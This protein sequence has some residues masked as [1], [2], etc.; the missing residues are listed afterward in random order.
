M[1]H[2]NNIEKI[3]DVAIIGGGINGVGIARDMAGRGLSVL[4]CEK[5]DLGGATSSASTK[6]IHGGLRYLEHLEFRLVRE[7]LSERAILMKSAPHIV[8]PLRFIMPKVAG[9]R[10]RWLLKLGLYLYDHL[11]A[12]G[13]IPS[14]KALDLKQD[15]AGDALVSSLKRPALSYWDCWT[16]DNRLVIL[17]AIDARDRGASIYTHM[18]VEKARR[19]NDLWHLDA[20]SAPSDEPPLAYGFKARSLV[21]AAGPWAGQILSD[22]IGYD[23]PKRLTLVKGSHIVVPRLFS[24]ESAYL[25]QNTDG[26]I[27]FAIPFEQNFTLIGTTD[28]VF[29]GDLDNPEISQEEIDYLIDVASKFFKKP[30]DRSDIIFSFTGVRPLYGAEDN[31]SKV[32]RDYHL[33]LDAPDNKAPL[34]NIFGGKLT[35]YRCL[36]QEA[37]HALGRTMPISSKDWTEKAIL[38]GG[39]LPY[40]A[41]FKRNLEDFMGCYAWLPEPLARRYLRTYGSLADR[42]LEDCNSFEDLGAEIAPDVYE[43]ELAYAMAHEWVRDG[44]DFLYRRTKL[45]LSTPEKDRQSVDRWLH[46]QASNNVQKQETQ[47]KI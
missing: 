7:S 14:A 2:T 27:I 8:T 30:P 3:F 41:D 43:A 35:T 4:L 32:S 25:F 11:A 37:V 29:K 15:Q 1:R 21:N 34:L 12:R 31:P 18:R 20:L 6:L 36:A 46:E 45:G 44:V 26:R 33:E 17:N 42:L 10:P 23:I 24:H 19:H 22:Q 13:D 47:L 9:G 39:D 40:G 28:I 16:E 5:G 38:P